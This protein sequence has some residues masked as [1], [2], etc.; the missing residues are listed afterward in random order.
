MSSVVSGLACLFE[1]FLA[2]CSNV[3]VYNPDAN[4]VSLK[5]TSDS[6]ADIAEGDV[7]QKTAAKKSNR[8]ILNSSLG[9]T[10]QVLINSSLEKSFLLYLCIVKLN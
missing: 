2:N 10:C 6:A 7:C 4:W 3:F 8:F 9:N 1:Q 5:E